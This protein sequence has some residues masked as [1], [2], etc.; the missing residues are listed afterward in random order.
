M[1]GHFQSPRRASAIGICTQKGKHFSGPVTCLTLNVLNA[2]EVIQCGFQGQ[3]LGALSLL[4]SVECCLESTVPWGSPSCPPE[5]I[6]W[7]ISKI[8]QPTTRTEPSPQLTMSPSP[9]SANI[10]W[11]RKT[12]QPTHTMTI[13]T[14]IYEE[15]SE[16]TNYCFKSLSLGWFVTQLYSQMLERL[17][18]PVHSICMSQPSSPQV[19][20]SAVTIL[21][22][23]FLEPVLISIIWCQFPR[24][25]SLRQG[26]MCV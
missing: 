1:T 8:R 20:V 23:C 4:F 6:T 2:V 17:Y 10:V 22:I 16:I 21:R 5:K 14:T 24:K 18:E 19:N 13:I 3:V 12:T 11:N 7:R 15:L 26:C 25:F 9:I